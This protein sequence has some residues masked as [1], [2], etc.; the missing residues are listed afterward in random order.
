LFVDIDCQ[1]GPREA[2]ARSVSYFDENHAVSIQ[3]DQVDL[4]VAATEV[5]RYGPQ[6]FVSQKSKCELLGMIP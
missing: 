6:T 2:S 5:P 3:H 4:S 1:G